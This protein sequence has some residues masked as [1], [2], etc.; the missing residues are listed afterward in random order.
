MQAMTALAW[1]ILA[2]LVLGAAVCAFIG[3]GLRR[4]LRRGVLDPRSDPERARLASAA[5]ISIA[6]LFAG[7][8]LILAL[9]FALI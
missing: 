1:L 8:A 3:Y 5:F 2:T 4:A 7:L 6:A 9:A